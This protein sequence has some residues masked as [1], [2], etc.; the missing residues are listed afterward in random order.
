MPE[1]AIAVPPDGMPIAQILKT[2]GLCPSTSDAL[3][4]IDQGGV[5]VD[6]E[7]VADKSLRLAAGGTHVIQVGKRKFARVALSR[8]A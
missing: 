5:R 1:H 6:G 4:M 7:K 8:A 3:R 2:A